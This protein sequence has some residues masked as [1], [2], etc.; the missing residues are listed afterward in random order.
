MGVLTKSHFHN[1]ERYP[2]DKEDANLTK[3]IHARINTNRAF[4]IATNEGFI[5]GLVESIH[6][7]Y[8]VAD[9]TFL[10][11]AMEEDK[12]LDNTWIRFFSNED[13]GILAKV[14]SKKE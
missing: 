9:L 10:G 6:D 3:M 1:F 14:V 8:V 5:I 2:S 13:E 7:D 4:P 11:R 12:T